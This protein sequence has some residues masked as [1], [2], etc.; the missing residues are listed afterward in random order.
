MMS[1]LGSLV[2][3]GSSFAF[4]VNNRGDV[5]GVASTADYSEHAFLW[6]ERAGIMDIG[7]FEPSDIN[8]RG[9]VVGF[10]RADSHAVM[11]TRKAG[12]IDLGFG[13]AHAVNNRGTIAGVC[14]AADWS[15]SHACTIWNGVS[16]DLRTL[17]GAWSYAT[18]I[19]SSGTVVGTTLAAGPGIVPFVWTPRG[20]MKRL[21]HPPGSYGFPKDINA[22]GQIVGCIREG[23][24]P[25]QAVLWSGGRL[26]RLGSLAGPSGFSCAA[27][28][29]SRG[30]VVGTSDSP[31]GWGHAFLWTETDGMI[32]LGG[33][34]GVSEAFDINDSGVIVGWSSDTTRGVAV[35]WQVR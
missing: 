30:Q 10:R 13:I 35:Q 1:E 31:A 33:L 26:V 4:A 32:D 22:R 2:P 5:V 21:P 24:L 16:I 28:I 17:G 15:D 3:G 14:G 19:N 9:D 29:N 27:A 34:G 6:S 18:S 23:D 8:D 12:L 25:D 11:L 7:V 20:G